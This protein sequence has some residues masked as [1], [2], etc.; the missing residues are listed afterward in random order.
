[1]RQL[2]RC[3][4]DIGAGLRESGDTLVWDHQWTL[5][6]GRAADPESR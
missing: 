2:A 3:G 5:V 1:M 4:I 6:I